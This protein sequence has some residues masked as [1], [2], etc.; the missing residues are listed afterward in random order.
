MRILL[1]FSLFNCLLGF[2]CSNK[3]NNIDKVNRIEVSLEIEGVQVP[4]D[5]NEYSLQFIYGNTELSG[6]LDGC[7]LLIPEFSNKTKT[8][9]VLFQYK[10]FKLEF[11]NLDV[12]W[13]N[14]DLKWNF[15]IDYPPFDEINNATLKDKS[16]I[17]I[18]YLQF[19]P[20]DGQAIEIINPVYK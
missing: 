1:L 20:E 17:E 5:C 9:T 4:T 16:P 18:H 10:E 7:Y 14:G 13:F 12:K 3:L 15:K 6:L 11:Q 2:N 8:V 19:L